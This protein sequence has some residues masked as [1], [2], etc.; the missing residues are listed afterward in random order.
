M[1]PEVPCSIAMTHNGVVMG[2]GLS[3]F[4]VHNH[5]GVAQGT[6]FVWGVPYH[7]VANPMTFWSKRR[8][9]SPRKP[10]RP[11]PAAVVRDLVH[12]AASL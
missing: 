10:Y 8:S 9:V 7:V 11:H 6:A 12:H 4:Y 5:Q 3:V 1:Q 2:Q